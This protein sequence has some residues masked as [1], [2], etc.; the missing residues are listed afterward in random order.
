MHTHD[1][2]QPTKAGQVCYKE[3][4]WL[5][6]HKQAGTR[7]G[8]HHRHT[9]TINVSPPTQDALQRDASAGHVQAIRNQS[10]KPAKAHR[11]KKRQPANADQQCPPVPCA[12]GGVVGMCVCYRDA[13]ARN[14]YVGTRAGNH[15]RNP[16]QMLAHQNRRTTLHDP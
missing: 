9:L 5:G 10:R 14:A 15:Q 13:M 16:Q 3:T 12:S 6:M 7:A 2:H 8:N 1:K 4:R 11:H